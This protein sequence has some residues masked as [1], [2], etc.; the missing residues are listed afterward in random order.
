M[1]SVGVRSNCVITTPNFECQWSKGLVILDIEMYFQEPS[2]YC[3]LACL[4]AWVGGLINT[5]CLTAHTYRVGGTVRAP[6]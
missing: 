1:Y 4:L 6:S 3:L 2:I 5:G